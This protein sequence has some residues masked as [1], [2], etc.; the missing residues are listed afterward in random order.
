[1]SIKISARRYI[2]KIGIAGEWVKPIFHPNED[3]FYF[4]I[5]EHRRNVFSMT[6]AKFIDSTWLTADKSGWSPTKQTIIC[7]SEIKI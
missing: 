4:V 6:C 1:M 3:N 7:W 5:L 2:E